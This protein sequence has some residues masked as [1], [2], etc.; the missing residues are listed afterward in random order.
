[1]KSERL[2]LGRFAA[3]SEFR[4]RCSLRASSSMR[5]AQA[6][7][8]VVKGKWQ[9]VAKKRETGRGAEAGIT[10]VMYQAG[11]VHDWMGLL[12][13]MTASQ[14]LNSGALFGLGPRPLHSWPRSRADPINHMIQG[15]L[16][17]PLHLT[18]WVSET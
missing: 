18:I 9:R 10:Y 3:K 4:T 5:V 6:G 16:H 2:R 8:Q 14:L 15:S 12:L 1:M 13:N 7:A 17:N 11:Y